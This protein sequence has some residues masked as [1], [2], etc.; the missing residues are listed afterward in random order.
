[1]S[2]GGGGGGGKDEDYD[3]ANCNR[4][5]FSIIGANDGSDVTGTLCGYQ[6]GHSSK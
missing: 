6:S 4:D 3:G 2:G 1:M 5:W